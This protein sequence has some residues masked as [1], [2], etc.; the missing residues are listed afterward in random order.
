MIGKYQ[1]KVFEMLRPIATAAALILS[2]Q[3]AVS[4]VYECDITKP[5]KDG[6]MGKDIIFGI[7]EKD[8]VAAVLDGVIMSVQDSPLITKVEVAPKRYTIRWEVKG[9]EAVEP[10]GS[11]GPVGYKAIILR[12]TNNWFFR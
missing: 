12:K 5:S 3:S 10:S 1:L 4:S 6:W 7:N 9:L 11:I 2:V 8:K